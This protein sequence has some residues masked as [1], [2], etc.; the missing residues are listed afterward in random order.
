M[1]VLC[2]PA[3]QNA[4]RT[5]LLL[6][7]SS[8]LYHWSYARQVAFTGPPP[9]ALSWLA[10]LIYGAGTREDAFLSSPFRACGVVGKSPGCKL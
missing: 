5:H 2:E 6:W 8:L 3:L 10:F 4:Q 1:Q 7:K 9:H